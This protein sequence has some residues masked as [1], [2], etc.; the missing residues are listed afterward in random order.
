MYRLFP[1]FRQRPMHIFM[2]L[3]QWEI[4]ICVNRVGFSFSGTTC[5]SLPLHLFLQNIQ[6]EPT[7]LISNNPILFGV[8]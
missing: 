7:N 1:C 6:A 5:F 2:Q 8:N 3:L 4:N